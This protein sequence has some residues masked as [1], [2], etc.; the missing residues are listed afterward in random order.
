MKAKHKERKKASK[1]T[2]GYKQ[3][4]KERKKNRNTKRYKDRKELHT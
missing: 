1:H 4:N 2:D 3:R